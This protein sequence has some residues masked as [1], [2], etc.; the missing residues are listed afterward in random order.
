MIWQSCELLAASA[1]LRGCR[2]SGQPSINGVGRLVLLVPDSQ[3]VTRYGATDKQCC[4]KQRAQIGCRGETF[5]ANFQSSGCS[6]TLASKRA[7][8]IPTYHVAPLC[9]ASPAPSP[10]QQR[11]ASH[12]GRMRE[13]MCLKLFH[14]TEPW[15]RARL[16]PSLSRHRKLRRVRT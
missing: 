7:L 6:M 8:R 12:S 11:P 4:A 13:A 1:S 10:R 2:G 3:Q 15:Q 5:K 9:K 14:V 16:Y